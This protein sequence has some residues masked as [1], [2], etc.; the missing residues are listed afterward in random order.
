M[1]YAITDSQTHDAAM[2]VHAAADL[3]GHLAQ[4][5]DAHWLSAGQAELRAEWA[6]DAYD[7]LVARMATI[8]RP[9]SGKDAA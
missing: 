6:F 7:R 5:S 1:T 3:M 8:P 9:G 4:L 2:A